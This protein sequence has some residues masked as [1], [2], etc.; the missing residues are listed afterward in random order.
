MASIQIKLFASLREAVGVDSMSL[1][2]EGKHSMAQVL[3]QLA[4]SSESFNKYY[5]THPI[6]IAVNQSMVDTDY[7]ITEQDEVALFPPVTGG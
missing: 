6:L 2:L 7:L 3:K 1:D 4:N 5:T